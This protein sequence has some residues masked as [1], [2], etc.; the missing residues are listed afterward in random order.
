MSIVVGPVTQRWMA[1]PHFQR[2]HLEIHAPAVEGLTVRTQRGRV[3]AT[4]IGNI[5]RVADLLPDRPPSPALLRPPAIEGILRQPAHLIHEAGGEGFALR[6][7]LVRHFF[8]GFR[9][10]A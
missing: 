7:N 5:G 6:E 10:R 4:N 3:T 8:T 1:E 9:W 2:A